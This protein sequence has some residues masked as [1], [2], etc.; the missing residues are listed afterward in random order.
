MSFEDNLTALAGVLQSTLNGPLSGQDG[1]KGVA[2]VAMWQRSLHLA[3]KEDVRCFARYVFCFMCDRAEGTHG[4]GHAV[5][6]CVAEEKCHNVAIDH[7]MDYLTF[8]MSLKDNMEQ[9]IVSIK[10]LNPMAQ[11]ITA[12]EFNQDI[13]KFKDIACICEPST[14]VAETE[15]NMIFGNASL[16]AQSNRAQSSDDKLDGI[17]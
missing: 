4:I 10:E 3:S 8:Q 13:Q 11:N 7:I 17:L 12:N 6:A 14:D 5:K 2:V 15:K 16:A 9:V 1:A